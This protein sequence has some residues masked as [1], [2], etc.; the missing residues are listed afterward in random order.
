MSESLV[1]LLVFIMLTTA[2]I[3]TFGYLTDWTF[4]PSE[5][6]KS[7]DLGCNDPSDDLKAEYP[8]T[9]FFKANYERTGCTPSVCESGFVIDTDTNQCVIDP[10]KYKGCYSHLNLEHMSQDDVTK[11]VFISSEN[12]L[13]YEANGIDRISGGV[14]K[15]KYDKLFGTLSE[16]SDIISSE[17]LGYI[18]NNTITGRKPIEYKYIGYTASNL[19]L[20]FNQL[21][22]GE[23]ITDDYADY[24][25]CG[26]VDGITKP[27]K[28]VYFS[29]YEIPSFSGYRDLFGIMERNKQFQDKEIDG[30]VLESST[31]EEYP[32]Q[33]FMCTGSKMDVSSGLVEPSECKRICD[34]NTNC[35]GFTFNHLGYY[36]PTQ[37]DEE[38]PPNLETDWYMYYDVYEQ[39]YYI[40]KNSCIFYNNIDHRESSHYSNCYIKE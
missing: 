11:I 12:D 39:P 37:W 7:S 18:N 6:A 30:Y 19:I 4:V 38:K 14:D 36:Y 13:F 27:T 17:E 23:R 26:S 8:N 28:D 35:K 22:Y 20:L 34:A 5:L 31:E 3:I 33:D 29:I 10:I 32:R 21:P 1:V 40:N 15:T 16:V 2:I 9:L 25:Y 24:V